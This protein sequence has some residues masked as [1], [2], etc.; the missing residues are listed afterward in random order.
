MHNPEFVVPVHRSMMWS[1]SPGVCIWEPPCDNF[2]GPTNFNGEVSEW[3]NQNMRSEI[4]LI[5]ETC[6]E[7]TVAKLCGDKPFSMKNY[8][9][10]A[11]FDN[12]HDFLLFKLRWSV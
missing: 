5:V 2:H 6:V 3:C 10:K 8:P 4:V 1:T 7:A 11:Y 9:G 12:E